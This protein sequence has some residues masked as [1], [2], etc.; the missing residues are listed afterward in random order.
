[1]AATD[2]NIENVLNALREQPD[3]QVAIME[4]TTGY[5]VN[6]NAR[7]TSP[8]RED[9]NPACFFKWENGLLKFKDFAAHFSLS[10]S[11]LDTLRLSSGNSMSEVLKY[12]NIKYNLCLG[13][14]PDLD[15]STRMILPINKYE[16]TSTSI[17]AIIRYESYHTASA[18]D[19][20]YQYGITDALLT[21]YSVKACKTVWVQSNK[22]TIETFHWQDTCP[23]F[24]YCWRSNGRL[25]D[26]FKMYRPLAQRAG[27]WRCNTNLIDDVGLEDQAVDF[28]TSSRKDRMVLELAGYTSVCGL[29]EMAVIDTNKYKAKYTFMDNDTAGIAAAAKYNLPSIFVPTST[30]NNN[31]QI[32]D[33]ADYAK[34]FGITALQTSIKEQIAHYEEIDYSSKQ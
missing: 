4:T 11:V 12:V 3:L 15:V 30:D 31:K 22:G 7:Y 14:D 34:V 8:F 28:I 33:P 17:P 16:A 19:Y 10:G 26:K 1:M 6:L 24:L 23:L 21:K 29:N 9:N 25:L 27:K 5:K 18:F 20:F 13:Y 32:K 2:L